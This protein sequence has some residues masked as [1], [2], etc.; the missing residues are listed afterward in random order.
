VTDINQLKIVNLGQKELPKSAIETLIS[1]KYFKLFIPKELGGLEN[2]LVE[3]CDK[4]LETAFIHPSLGW[5]H[6]LGAGA[7]FFCGFFNASTARTVFSNPGVITSGSGRPSG[8]YIEESNT[9]VLTG[10][11]DKCSG[12]NFATHLT[13]VGRNQQNPEEIK[14]FILPADGIVLKDDWKTYGLK[15]SAS[16]SYEL[17]NFKV[18]KSATFKINEVLSFENYPIYH[19]PFD[20]FARICLS[21]TLDGIAQRFVADI[22]TEIRNPSTDLIKSLEKMEGILAELLQTRSKLADL[23]YLQA[24][25]QLSNGFEKDFRSLAGLHKEIYHEASEIFYHAGVR[26]TEE[27]SPANWSFRDLTTAIQHYMLK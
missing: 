17:E 22:K 6:N 19:I 12:A 25:N 24:L 14:A 23:V 13:C 4:L 18:D 15:A 26:A 20:W 5:V 3:A 11:W 2:N 27:E 1:E 10:S 8:T 16:Y 9:F 7:N 21:A